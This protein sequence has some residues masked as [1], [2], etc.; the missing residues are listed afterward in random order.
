MKDYFKDYRLIPVD[1]RTPLEEVLAM[2][3]EYNKKGELVYVDYGC[4]KFTS[5]DIDILEE[6]IQNIDSA[7]MAVYGMKRES[8]QKHSI[9]VDFLNFGYEYVYPELHEDWMYVVNNRQYLYKFDFNELVCIMRTLEKD[10]MDAALQEYFRTPNKDGMLNVIG[11]FSKK[12]PEF[13]RRVFQ[14]E[15]KKLTEVHERN[16]KRLEDRLEAY[17]KANTKR[18]PVACYGDEEDLDKVIKALQRAYNRGEYISYEFEG[19]VISNEE[20]PE[21][22]AVYVRVYGVSKE[23]LEHNKRREEFLSSLDERIEHGK[24]YIKPELHEAFEAW[25]RKYASDETRVGTEISLIIGTLTK[26]KRG[27]DDKL[28]QSIFDFIYQYK[29]NGYEQEYNTVLEQVNVFSEHGE[30]FVRKMNEFE[31][32]MKKGTQLT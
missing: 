1:I 8:Y 30:L 9:E 18:Q 27:T 29:R 15:G 32:T 14:A 13:Y 6:D 7:Y 22:D 11:N 2:L 17:K 25:C 20:R 24:L 26:L 4:V 5:G 21:V 28:M 31:Q 3:V 19:N 12:G 16:L 10:G 23:Q